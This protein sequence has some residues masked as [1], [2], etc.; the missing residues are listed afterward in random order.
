LF[1]SCV[2]IGGKLQ[3]PL[4]KK[5]KEE[6]LKHDYI[7]KRKAGKEIIFVWKFIPSK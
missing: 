6:N 1:I 5:R 3:K 4:R 2:N 7:K